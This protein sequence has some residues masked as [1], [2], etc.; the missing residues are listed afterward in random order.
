MKTGLEYCFPETFRMSKLRDF[1][2]ELIN[3]HRQ[4]K[5]SEERKIEII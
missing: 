3:K 2:T 1:Q 5:I 4:V